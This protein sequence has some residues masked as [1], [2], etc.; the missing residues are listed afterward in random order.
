MEK[1]NIVMPWGETLTFSANLARAEVPI[2]IVSDNE[3]ITTQYLTAHAKHRLHDAAM[4]AIKYMGRDWYASPDDDR[5]NEEILTE[6]EKLVIINN[7]A[8]G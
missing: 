8:I 1:Y 2:Y 3:E 4:L 7:S 6:L 5:S